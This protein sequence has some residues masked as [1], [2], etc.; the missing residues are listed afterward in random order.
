MDSI[1]KRNQQEMMARSVIKRRNVIYSPQP[2]EAE[3]G[4]KPEGLAEEDIKE[5]KTEQEAATEEEL[6]VAQDILKRLQREADAD[7]A[8][9]REAIEK[10]LAQQEEQKNDIERILQ[11]KQANLEKTM[12]EARG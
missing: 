8:A 10:L 2:I 9:K 1:D 4:E 11:E 12:A 6:A 7:E 3:N 5:N